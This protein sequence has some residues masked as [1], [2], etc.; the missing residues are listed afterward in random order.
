MSCDGEEEVMKLFASWK[1]RYDNWVERER[2]KNDEL[3]QKGDREWEEV[4]QLWRRNK[5][6]KKLD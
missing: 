2:V 3:R 4:K 6:D 5:Q 1:V